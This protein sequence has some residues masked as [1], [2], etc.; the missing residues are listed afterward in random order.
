[1]ERLKTNRSKELYIGLTVATLLI[2]GVLNFI[3]SY[4]PAYWKSWEDLDRLVIICT[5]LNHIGVACSLAQGIYELVLFIGVCGDINKICRR[6]NIGGAS[7]NYF[8]V[9]LLSAV[10]LGIYYVW[11]SNSQGKC[12]QAASERYHVRVKGRTDIHLVL[13]ILSTIFLW[14]YAMT[15]VFP[16]VYASARGLSPEVYVFHP[17][18][19]LMSMLLNLAYGLMYMFN[20]AYFIEDVNILSAAYNQSGVA[21]GHSEYQAAIKTGGLLFCCRGAYRGAE[22]PVE[23]EIIIGRD[24]DCSHI[25]IQSEKVSRKHCG[26]R[27]DSANGTYM[28]TDYSANGLYD[29]TGRAF[30]KN[31]PVAC[32]AGVTLVIAQSGNEFLLK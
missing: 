30:P 26:I 3:C 32:H 2:V 28:V 14:A 5:V 17:F 6:W 15:E 12:L 23:G 8:L 7:P 21:Y 11:W 9:R 13:A 31:V 27:Y 19:N 16:Q 18:I 20:M 1:M 29:K 10:T 24:A 22:F 25:V 4:L